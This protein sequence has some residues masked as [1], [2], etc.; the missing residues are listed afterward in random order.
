MKHIY[1]RLTIV[2]VLWAFL[3]M[4]LLAQM[5]HDGL[6]MPKRRLCSAIL[7]GHNAFSKYWEGVLLRDNPNIGTNVQQSI[8]VMAN[9]GLTD[10]LNAIVHLPYIRTHNTAGNLRGQHGLQDLSFWVKYQALRYRGLSLSGAVGAAVPV[11][12]YVPD[13]L[14]M[15][16]GLHCRML[17]G[18]FIAHYAHTSGLYA[19]AHASYVWRS[20]IFIDRDSYQANG[21]LVNS[22]QVSVPNALDGAV[23]LGY[24]KQAVQVE[25][26][27]QRFTCVHGDNIRRN[28]M[29]FPTNNMQATSVGAYAKWQARHLGFNAQVA[30]VLSGLNVGKSTQYMAGVLWQW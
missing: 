4:P 27:L 21:R 14:P 6:Y 8:A 15:S 7:Y 26:F 20:N 29:P 16:I 10:R 3:G 12:D 23:R 9:Y 2:S 17:T 30:Q 28:D 13:F 5:P 24:L 18:R 25:G 1:Q 22:N 19:T 11:S